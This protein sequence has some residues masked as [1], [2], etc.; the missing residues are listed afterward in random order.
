MDATVAP[1]P[2]WVETLKLNH[3]RNYATLRLECDRRH[4]VLTGQNG[5]GKTNLLE[6]ISFLSP[7]RGLRRV[8]YDRVA[9]QERGEMPYDPQEGTWAVH[10]ILHG[11]VGEVA[12]GTGLQ[13]GSGNRRIHVNGT[14]AKTS[15]ELLDHCRVVW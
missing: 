15:E 12:V 2:V 10:A 1:H 3:F 9:Q 6:A 11:A 13:K 8:A 7:G 4:V 14:A 5:A